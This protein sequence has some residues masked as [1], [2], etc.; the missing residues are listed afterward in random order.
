[1]TT[2]ELTGI[3]FRWLGCIVLKE[4]D[5]GVGRGIKW[6]WGNVGVEVEV[7]GFETI[8][9]SELGRFIIDVCMRLFFEFVFVVV[10]A[11]FVEVALVFITMS[12]KRRGVVFE[13]GL[14]LYI[15]EQKTTEAAAQAIALSEATQL[16]FFFLHNLI[17]NF[18]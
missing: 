4:R 12:W 17:L 5:G 1:M 2:L 14:V 11:F 6:S 13:R 9:F 10:D 3:R 7:G 8:H 15:L 16:I 18:L